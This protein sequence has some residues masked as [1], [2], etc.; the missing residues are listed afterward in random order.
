ML[1]LSDCTSVASEITT[2]CLRYI[3]KS[4]V[5]SST[6]IR[7]A[8][9]F[10]RYCRLKSPQWPNTDRS[11]ASTLQPNDIRLLSR[12]VF[13]LSTKSLTCLS[14]LFVSAHPKQT[15]SNVRRRSTTLCASN[16]NGHGHFN[17]PLGVLLR[18]T[19]GFVACKVSAFH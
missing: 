8:L 6:I 19:S 7:V 4:H 5:R 12:T 3:A 10:G 9:I 1:R 11:H 2:F 18:F 17:V 13:F 15:R 16:Q 14:D